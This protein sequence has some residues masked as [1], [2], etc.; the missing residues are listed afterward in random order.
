MLYKAD[1]RVYVQKIV[2]DFIHTYIRI[3][4]TYEFHVTGIHIHMTPV[5]IHEHN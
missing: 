5:L 3:Y 1:N 4:G 2:R